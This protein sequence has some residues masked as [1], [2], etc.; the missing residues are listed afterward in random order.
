[1]LTATLAQTD[2]KE[3]QS[4]PQDEPEPWCGRGYRDVQSQEE[5]E[6]AAKKLGLGVKASMNDFGGVSQCSYDV[7]EYDFS[8]DQWGAKQNLTKHIAICKF[9][10]TVICDIPARSTIVNAERIGLQETSNF[11]VGNQAVNFWN[12]RTQRSQILSYPTEIAGGGYFSGSRDNDDVDQRR[13]Q[14]TDEV[15]LF[16]LTGEDRRYDC[17]LDNWWTPRRTRR[18]GYYGTGSWSF[19]SNSGMMRSHIFEVHGRRYSKNSYPA[20]V[21]VPV[22]NGGAMAMV[23]FQCRA[24]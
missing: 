7:R 2:K 9:D 22:C 23:A 13:V 11:P 17:G 18:Y 1:L 14:I 16:F 6:I 10:T 15:E 3:Y 21:A 20:N 8:R 19:M 4:F 5:C 24:A 12:D